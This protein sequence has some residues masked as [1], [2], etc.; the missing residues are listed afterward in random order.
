GRPGLGLRRAGVEVA[1]A[2]A[3][4]ALGRAEAA[5]EAALAACRAR[6]DARD[7]LVGEDAPALLRRTRDAGDLAVELALGALAAGVPPGRVARAALDA[8]E[9]GRA[10]SLLEGVVHRDALLAAHVPAALREGEATARAALDA[11]RRRRLDAAATPAPDDDAAADRALAEAYRAHAEAAD[12]VGREARAVAATVFP[13]P[14]DADAVAATLAP[15]EAAIVLHVGAERATAVVVRPGRTAAPVLCD[16]GPGRPLVEAADAWRRAA[17]APGSDDRA[18]ASALHA[19]VVAPM[20]AAL[21]GARRWVV[22]PDAVVA[23]AP[24]AAM[25]DATGPT[26]RRLVEDVEVVLVP[27]LTFFAAQRADRTPPGTGVLALGGPAFRADGPDALPPLPGARAEAEAVAAAW[28][29]DD[30][31]VL[32]GSDATEARLRAALADGRRRALVHVATHAFADAGFPRLTHLALAGD[33]AWDLDEIQATPVR[34]DVV[35]LS[36]C[37]TATGTTLQGEGV[38]GLARSFLLAGARRVVASAWA[39]DDG[40]TRPLMERF[41]AGLASGDGA[42]A[43]LRAAQRAA[44]ATGGPGAHPSRWAAFAVWGAP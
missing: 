23:T 35:V 2:H 3:L 26:P 4:R 13:H 37:A 6:L 30:R 44:L 21:A 11:A 20:R 18:L 39:V 41:A 38:V 25:L 40:A 8:A 24:F 14:A 27:S 16:L 5:L 15:D 31:T 32:V 42:A 22:A 12:R 29:A 36:A 9:A 33:D 17:S 28:P 34:A 43:A 19:R 7:G 10:L 1:R